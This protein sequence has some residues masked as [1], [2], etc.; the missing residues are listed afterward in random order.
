MR[1][2]IDKEYLIHCFEE[3]VSVPS[4]VSYSVKL[5]SVLERY[6]AQYGQSVTYDNRGTAYITLEGGDNSKTILLA[7]HCDTLGMVVR[8]IDA[9]GMIRVRQ[10]GGVNYGSLEG[11]SVTVHTRDGREYTG[12]IACQSHSV[13]VFDDARTLERTENTMIVLLDEEVHSRED[14]RAL[15]IRHGDIISVDPHCEYTKNGYLKSRFIDDKAAVACVFTMLKYLQEQGLKPKYRTMLAFTYGEE[16]GLGG[17]YVPPEVSEYVAIDIGLIG[18]DYDGHERCVTICSKD[19]AAPYSY[20][21]TNRLIA[22]AEKAGC[23]YAVDI[24]YR[25]GTDAS[26]AMKSCNNIQIGAFGMPV[27]CSHGRERTHL[28]SLTNTLNLLLAYV[29]DI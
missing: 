26:A 2:P 18:P 19:N 1:F 28:L 27:Y 4:P 13:H 11:E 17:P 9:N 29:L 23:D 6:A 22:Y 10:L 12:L 15:G 8:T 20:E 24:F 25:Y 5:N 21:L 3:L 16:I 7:A 14:V